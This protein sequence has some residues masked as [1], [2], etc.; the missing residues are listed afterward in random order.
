MLWTAAGWMLSA[1]VIKEQKVGGGILPEERAQ[2]SLHHAPCGLKLDSSAS[3]AFVP[4]GVDLS[5]DVFTPGHRPRYW[6][7]IL[8]LNCLC[9]CPAWSSSLLTA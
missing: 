2:E 1:S 9:R 7:A 6:N 8:F 4:S 3:M 5:S